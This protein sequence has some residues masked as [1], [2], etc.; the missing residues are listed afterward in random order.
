[1]S[2]VIDV[3]PLLAGQCPPLALSVLGLMLFIN[4]TDIINMLCICMEPG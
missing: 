1:M 4:I 2:S 3:D